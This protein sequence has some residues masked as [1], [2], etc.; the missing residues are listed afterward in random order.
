[1][2]T[3]N[4]AQLTK[5]M[6]VGQI[7]NLADPTMVAAEVVRG[8]LI[9]RLKG[10]KLSNYEVQ[11]VVVE[12][13][14]GAIAGMVLMEVPLPRGAAAILHAA[15]VSSKSL[16]YDKHLMTTAAIKGIADVRRFTTKEIIGQIR[17]RINTTWLG[18]GEIFDHFSADLHSSQSHPGYV[19]PK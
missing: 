4:L 1:M 3:F 8:T 2:E 5:E 7:K 6:V 10:H 14:K 11:D 9:A 16:P 12:I 13:C 19:P 15:E 17:H 18:S